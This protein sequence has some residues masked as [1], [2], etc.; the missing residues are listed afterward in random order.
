[1]LYRDPR[2]CFYAYS[3]WQHAGHILRIYQHGLHG[4]PAVLPACFIRLLNLLLKKLKH[5][6]SG[7]LERMGV[8]SR[9]HVSAATQAAVISVRVPPAA[10][11]QRCASATKL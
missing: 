8:Q 10:I 4:F 7:V 5:A 1:M 6:I 9:V 2:Q 3:T 11:L